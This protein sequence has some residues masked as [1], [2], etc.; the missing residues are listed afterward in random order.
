MMKNAKPHNHPRVSLKTSISD[1]GPSK[2]RNSISSHPKGSVTFQLGKST[3]TSHDKSPGISKHKRQLG[4]GKRPRTEAN[5]KEDEVSGCN[6][7]IPTAGK[8]GTFSFS[9]Q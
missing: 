8:E 4:L 6:E 7:P 1:P 2:Q 9:S 5:S 3:P